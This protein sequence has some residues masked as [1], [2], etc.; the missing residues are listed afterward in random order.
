MHPVSSTETAPYHHT[1]KAKVYGLSTLPLANKF[2]AI[3][4]QTPNDGGPGIP[5]GAVAD[6]QFVEYN[7]YDNQIYDFGQGPSQTTVNAPDIGVTTAT[8]I[9]ITGTVMDVSA[10][11]KQTAQAQ[12]FQTVF[13]A[14]L[15]QAK[16]MDGVRLHAESR[17]NQLYRRSSHAYT[18]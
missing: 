2:G 9:T 15:T 18:S 16:V 1:I 3:L 8:P 7:Y 6:G 11:T 13:H 17:A 10:G 14:H 4:F 5:E 12:T